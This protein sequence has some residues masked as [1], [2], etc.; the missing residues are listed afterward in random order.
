MNFFIKYKYIFA[1]SLIAILFF[2]LFIP[3]LQYPEITINDLIYHKIITSHVV[4][5]ILNNKVALDSWIPEWEMGFPALQYYS[6]LHYFIIAFVYLL[7]GKLFSLALLINFFLLLS[8]VLTPLSIY[9]FTQKINLSPIIGF[10]AGIVSLLIT[11]QIYGIGYTSYFFTNMGLL[12]QAIAVPFFFLALGYSWNYIESKNKLLPAI[13]FSSITFLTHSLLGFILLISITF[14]SLY[15]FLFNKF[16]KKTLK[17]YFILTGSFL[18]VTS[19]QWLTTIIN[20]KYANQSLFD[21]AWK[22][23]S[24]GAVDTIN[25]LFSG[26]LFDGWWWANIPIITILVGIGFITFLFSK[27]KNKQ[28]IAFLFLLWLLLLFGRPFWGNII[29]IIPMGETFPWHRAIAGVQIF[30]IILAGSGLYEI[31]NL[32][33]VHI[34]TNRRIKLI[35]AFFLAISILIIPIWKLK[36]YIIYNTSSIIQHNI[37]HNNDKGILNGIIDT[38]KPLSENGIVHAGLSQT[39]SNDLK[40][41]NIS[42]FH[43]LPQYNIAN[44]GYQRFPWAPLVDHQEFY[45]PYRQA[46]NKLF[47]I[48]ALIYPPNF[49]KPEFMQEIY[50]NGRFKIAN[51]GEHSYFD[52]VSTSQTIYANKITDLWHINYQWLASQLVEE[53]NHFIYKLEKKSNATS[54]TALPNGNIKKNDKII[55][56]YNDQQSSI[57]STKV[58]ESI[59][60]VISET[61]YSDNH[62]ELTVSVNKES[63]LLFKQNYHPGWEV[64]LNNEKKDTVILSP[65]MVGVK[66]PPGEHIIKVQYKTP[67]YKNILFFVGIIY[68]MLLIIHTIWKSKRK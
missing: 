31:I 1:L 4:D 45:N 46:H 56:I 18:I 54:I 25:K 20:H 41:G 63:Y 48:S 30:G 58:E 64:T 38:I 5:S 39:F 42:L 12:S 65:G 9:F 17:S 24:Y 11:D 13:I 21:Y 7:F 66:L 51:T 52:I 62:Y 37:S 15:K 3:E 6:Y 55:N 43:F 22:Y 27:V 16:N 10:Y 28:I 29:N 33:Y 8:F 68:I 57:F 26:M 36:E 32:F 61:K 40:I 47:N 34:N 67:Q 23:D 50:D 19:H 59:G 53:K 35:F 49:N 60:M 44:L 14:I 2:I